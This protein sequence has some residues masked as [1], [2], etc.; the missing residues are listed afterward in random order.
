MSVDNNNNHSSST[1]SNRI[2][3]DSGVVCFFNAS[4]NEDTNLSSSSYSSASAMFLQA[5]R[6]QDQQSESNSGS[7]SLFQYKSVYA[8]NTSFDGI[9]AP[10]SLITCTA[11]PSSAIKR[12]EKR[13]NYVIGSGNTEQN[14]KT[15]NAG[16]YGSKRL[17]HVQQ[18]RMRFENWCQLNAE[19]K[20]CE[21][22]NC[23][24]AGGVIR[25]DQKFDSLPIIPFVK[26]RSDK[27]A[28]VESPPLIE[29]TVKNKPEG[30]EE[31]QEASLTCDCDSE[32]KEDFRENGKPEF[33]YFIGDKCEGSDI[34]CVAC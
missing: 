14:V 27:A 1:K 9:A 20:R 10:T 31:A 23:K 28:V 8:R 3:D 18:M 26:S 25:E 24:G 6:I 19:E 13:G 22:V 12:R 32:D 11:A 29:V 5:E 17:T 4:S 15:E 33:Y 21:A 2:S 7:Q 30:D 16:K 34:L